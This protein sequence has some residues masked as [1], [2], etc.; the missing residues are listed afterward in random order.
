MRHAVELGVV[1]V[2]TAAFSFRQ[3]R[4]ANE[5]ISTALQPYP[6]HLLLATKVGPHRDLS[7]AWLPPEQ[8]RG[9][10]EENLR[11]LGRDHVDL[12]YLRVQDAGPVSAHLDALR[13][14]QQGGLVGHLG[15][16]RVT[17]A[18][19]QE[20]LPYGVVSVQNRYP[21]DARGGTRCCAC[22]ASTAS[23]SCR[24]SRSPA[25]ARSGAPPRRTTR[26][27]GWRSSGA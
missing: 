19:L 10:V 3:S 1:H 25:R 11:Q 24:S 8:L 5:L 12:V 15:V 23:P 17:A 13:A 9:Q 22:A 2:D 16:S 4:S 7:G 27:C 26:W 21:L 14:L 6:D 20:A 18:Q